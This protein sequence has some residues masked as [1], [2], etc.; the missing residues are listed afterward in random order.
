MGPSLP[1]TPD[2]RVAA[3]DPSAVLNLVALDR[4]TADEGRVTAAFPAETALET[5]LHVVA[6]IQVASS[7]PIKL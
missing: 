1:F 5:R 7:M 2:P 3:A 4:S 6:Q